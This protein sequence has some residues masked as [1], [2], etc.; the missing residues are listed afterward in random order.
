MTGNWSFAQDDPQPTA[1]RNE[2][3]QCK[4]HPLI[5]RVP[6]PFGHLLAKAKGTVLQV[7]IA[8]AIQ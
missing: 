3:L 1:I 7:Q 8:E 5:V 4:V 2:E 6:D